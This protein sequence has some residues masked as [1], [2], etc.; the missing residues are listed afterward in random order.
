MKWNASW[1]H[2]IFFIY[3]YSRSKAFRVL[4]IIDLNAECQINFSSKFTKVTVTLF[5]VY[6][7]KL[8]TSCGKV[9]FCVLGRW[10]ECTIFYSVPPLL[11]RPFSPK[12]LLALCTEHL[13]V[14][15]GSWSKRPMQRFGNPKYVLEFEC[16]FFGMLCV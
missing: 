3:K 15:S 5:L 12:C 4:R 7:A 8:E 11:L 13:T 6:S 2:N 10:L 1:I 9:V 14:N 16:I